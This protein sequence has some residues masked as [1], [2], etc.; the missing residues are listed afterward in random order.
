MYMLQ[1]MFGFVNILG[2]NR[3]V[4][5]SKNITMQK[6]LLALWSLKPCY[7]TTCKLFWPKTSQLRRGC[8]KV[9]NASSTRSNPAKKWK[10][11]GQYSLKV[12]DFQRLFWPKKVYRQNS[13]MQ[14]K[15]ASAPNELPPATCRHPICQF[16]WNTHLVCSR[17][18]QSWKMTSYKK[19][20]KCNRRLLLEEESVKIFD[21]E[22][23]W[24]D[25]QLQWECS[26]NRRWRMNL[27][28][29]KEW[30]P[31]QVCVARRGICRPD[32]PSARRRWP[33]SKVAMECTLLDG[34]EGLTGYSNSFQK[35]LK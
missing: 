31:F 34:G 24:L 6:Y 8:H 32:G 19:T 14:Q 9:R 28:A 10:L 11:N 13:R 3:Q 30:M 16:Q 2:S 27:H 21:S 12:Q 26:P 1:A 17:Q 7:H 4:P 15:I 18:W 23:A 5:R 35:C 20:W 25:P 33:G 29:Y 22:L